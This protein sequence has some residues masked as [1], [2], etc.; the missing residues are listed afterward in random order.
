MESDIYYCFIE[1]FYSG[2]DDTLL[3]AALIKASKEYLEKAINLNVNDMMDDILKK[4]RANM[5]SAQIDSF[6]RNYIMP[7][8]LKIDDSGDVSVI[9]GKR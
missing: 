3:T 4:T 7:M 8:H 5:T 9:L 6:K 2:T 1:D